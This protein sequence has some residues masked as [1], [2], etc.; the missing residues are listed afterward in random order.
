MSAHGIDVH[1]F[2]HWEGPPPRIPQQH[3]IA[4]TR[5][6]A[7]GVAL[8][9]LGKWGDPFEVQV[10][11]HYATL[12]D[13]TAAFYIMSASVGTGWLAVKYANLN[14]TGLYSTG[15][16]AMMVE[17]VDLRAAAVLIG[18]GYAYTNGAVLVTRWTLQP[19]QI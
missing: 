10:T 2:E 14:Y 1:N 6:G 4:H 19:E 15:Y 7:N 5:P 18:P 3:S 11:S 9:L 8:Q 17:Q 13:A 16:H 12:L